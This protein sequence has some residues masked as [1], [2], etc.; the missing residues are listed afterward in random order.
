MF[1]SSAAYAQPSFDILAN[2]RNSTIVSPYDYPITNP[3]IS[4]LSFKAARP[5]ENVR[6][7]IMPLALH[8]ERSGLPYYGESYILNLAFFNHENNPKAPL[9]FIVPGIG[10]ATL[11]PS[12]LFLGELLFNA[13][14]NVVTLPST[15][16][17]QF[18]LSV[19]RSGFPGYSPVDAEDMLE[20]MKKADTL[21]RQNEHIDPHNYA[22][23]GFSLGALDSSFIANLDL[24]K[25]YFNFERILML[26]PPIQKE[27]SVTSLDGLMEYG[28]TIPENERDNLLGFATRKLLDA[29]IF[30]IDKLLHFNF[31][32]QF[33]LAD[34]QIAWMIGSNFRR[35]LREV[36]LLSQEI[37]EM[38]VLKT[39]P[40][41]LFRTIREAE[42]M[43]FSFRDYINKF[44][45]AKI[46]NANLYA[47][48]FRSPSEL[49]DSSDMRTQITSLT[50]HNVK[51]AI[52]HNQNDFIFHKEDLDY[53]LNSN[54]DSR[55]YPLGGHLGNL[56]FEKNRVDIL[57]YLAPL[58]Y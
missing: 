58:S 31:E 19:S 24:Q 8:P 51:W 28:S 9:V 30:S 42:A 21:L 7:K 54:S 29:S 34:P 17:W 26:N 47:T 2:P 3:Y 18:A 36:I 52:F 53:L 6:Y 44:L 37:D 1:F 32:N 49:I 5:S 40:N 46:K 20:L 13:G 11:R 39:P 23:L 22:I 4:T 33:G 10:G 56:W 55:I 27:K 41:P 48:H 38:G 12:S 16:S 15:L 35:T 45:Y 43:T 50:D 25:H 14:Y 57:S